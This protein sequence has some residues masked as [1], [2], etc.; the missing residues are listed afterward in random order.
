MFSEVPQMKQAFEGK[1]VEK[2]EKVGVWDLTDEGNTVMEVLKFT[3]TDGSNVC[4]MGEIDDASAFST[5]VPMEIDGN[6]LK[7]SDGREMPGNWSR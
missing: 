3:F 2:V 1:T 4:V 6:T 5:V 7:T